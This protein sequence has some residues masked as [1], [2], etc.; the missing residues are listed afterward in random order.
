MRARILGVVL[1]LVVVS[2]ALVALQARQDDVPRVS[3]GA[4]VPAGTTASTPAPAAALPPDV[5][6]DWMRPLN[7]GEKPPQFVLFSF[8]GAGSH[9]HWQRMLDIG[10][11]SNATFSAFL[12]GIYL[13][14]NDQRTRYTGPGHAAGRASIGFGGPPDEVRTRIDD[15]NTARQRGIEIG[16]H[17]NGHFCRG[18]EPSVG[19][20]DAQMWRQELDEFFTFVTQAPGL[21]LDPAT[22]KGGRTPCLEGRFDVLFPVLAERGMTYDSSRV[23][24]GLG[25]PDKENGVWE[26]PMPSVRVP[27]LNR[28]VIMMDYNLWVSLNQARE[29]RSKRDEFA[30]VTL[31]T[32]R[33]AYNAA[34]QGNRAPLVIGNHFNDWAGGA[35]ALAVERFMPEVCA[36]PATICTTYSQVIKWM[37]M[38]PPEVLRALR[39]QPN[40]QT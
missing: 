23:S 4:G 18:A 35:F 28:K 17:Y 25:W 5:E 1:A 3:T 30:E 2:I 20:W 40:A 29:D 6:P 37:E 32:Y 16:T 19:R 9:E 27:A 15:L 26:F 7:P 12:S 14:S 39:K 24:D 34:L 11:R 33:A 31:D 38:Q 36:K 21:R 10:Q 22:V 8:D 13:L